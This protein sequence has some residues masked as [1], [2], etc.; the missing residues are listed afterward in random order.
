MNK[1]IFNGNI[2]SEYRG[3]TTFTLV[4]AGIIY[5]ACATLFLLV[6]LLYSNVDPQG[7][8]A[9]LIISAVT[10]LLAVLYPSITLFGIRKYPK[11]SKLTKLLIK[12]YVFIDNVEKHDNE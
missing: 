8:I 12:D 1:D 11:Y 3:L 5:L 4:F 6:A 10:Y 2:K 7:R 9:L